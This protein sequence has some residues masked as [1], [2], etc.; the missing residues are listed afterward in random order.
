MQKMNLTALSPLRASLLVGP[1]LALAQLLSGWAAAV[2]QAL[3]WAVGG[4]W[5]VAGVLP[6][7]LARYQACPQPCSR[8]RPFQRAWMWTMMLPWAMRLLA[9]TTTTTM[10]VTTA[11]SMATTRSCAST[12][13]PELPST[14]H[15]RC[16]RGRALV[17]RDAVLIFV[18]ASLRK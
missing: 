2:A 13:S 10:A 17:R 4:C 14:Q 16:L 18:A 12:K 15:L 9:T 1:L 3:V 11:T 8:R 6:R 7:A 5:G